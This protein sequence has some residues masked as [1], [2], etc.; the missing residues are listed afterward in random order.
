MQKI[1][2]MSDQQIEALCR[3]KGHDPKDEATIGKQAAQIAMLKVDLD[4]A[5]ARYADLMALKEQVHKQLEQSQKEVAE[6]RED[7]ARLDYLER[8]LEAEQEQIKLHG[9]ANLHRQ[10]S[11]FRRNVPITR[12]A[13]DAALKE[14]R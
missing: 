14:P 6:L 3:L 11:L 5:A 8:E 12:A 4:N 2:N 9:Y 1:L 10:Q 7:A 13:I